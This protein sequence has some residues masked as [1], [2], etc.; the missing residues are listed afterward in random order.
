MFRLMQLKNLDPDEGIFVSLLS[1]CGSADIGI[2]IHKHLKGM[3]LP[4]TVQINTAD[5]SG[6][7]DDVRRTRKDIKERGVVKTPG[8][9]SIEV[10][11][12]I[13]EFVAGFG[14]SF[15][16]YMMWDCKSQLQN[17]HSL[18]YSVDVKENV[19]Q[20]ISYVEQQILE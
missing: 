11:G 18:V 7:Y 9:S 6:K 20:G 16:V 12:F 19:K 13:H 1:A 14:Y 17:L 10:N 2:W 3:Q 8:C 4:M 15:A 5:C